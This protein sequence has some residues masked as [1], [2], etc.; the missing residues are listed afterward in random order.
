M[1]KVKIHTNCRKIK[2]GACEF[3]QW[4]TNERAHQALDYLTPDK[5]AH[6]FMDKF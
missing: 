4:Y 2:N 6:G 3:M 5:K 1:V